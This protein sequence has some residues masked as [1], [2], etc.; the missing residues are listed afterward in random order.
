[1]TDEEEKRII[2]PVDKIHSFV[3]ID[4]NGIFQEFTCPG[5]SNHVRI[6]GKRPMVYTEE[7]M[8]EKS[9]WK[10]GEFEILNKKMNYQTRPN[11]K[12]RFYELD[13]NPPQIRVEV[14]SGNR[15]TPGYV[16]MDMD[17]D[18]SKIDI[19]G[20]L[21]DMPFDDESVDELKMIHVVEHLWWAELFWTFGEMNRVL[22]KGGLLHIEVPDLDV[23]IKR[24][25]EQVYHFNMCLYA[26]FK[27]EKDYNYYA[28]APLYMMHHCTF[29]FE[30]LKW[31]LEQAGFGDIMRDK[32]GEK[33]SVH[34]WLGVLS[35][36]ATKVGKPKS[37]KELITDYWVGINRDYPYLEKYLERWG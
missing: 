22:K 13:F 10:F 28:N 18:S 30:I 36:K 14:G 6:Y 15:P 19:W 33:E 37:S 29:N 11:G 16:H 5:C 7:Q 25:P 1:M 24:P 9:K 26:E 23:A 31:Y 34:G 20:N 17:R 35:V 21:K 2:Q 3:G 27:T 32:A 12:I 4:G 8:K